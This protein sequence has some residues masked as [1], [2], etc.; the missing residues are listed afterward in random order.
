MAQSTTG[1][2]T[3]RRRRHCRHSSLPGSG[4]FRIQGRRENRVGHRRRHGPVGQNLPHQRL[5]HVY[6][7]SQTG[8]GRPTP[9]H[10]I[11][12]M[13]DVRQVT[14]KAGN[15]TATLRQ[16]PRFIDLERAPPAVNA[17]RCAPS[18]SPID[19]DHGPA[20]P[21]GGLQAL[22]P[23]HAGS[24]RHREKRDGTL[25]GRLPCQP[26]RPGVRSHSWPRANTRRPSNCSNRT[27]P[28]PASAAGSATTPAKPPAPAANWMNP[29]SIMALHRFLADW[30]REN[31]QLPRSP[32]KSKKK[33]KI[34]VV[35]SGPAGLTCAYFLAIDGICDV[36][37]FE[38]HDVLGGM[39]TLG[40]PSYR[41]PRDI[42]DELK[43]RS[44][45]FGRQRL[46]P[47]SILVKT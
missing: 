47:V 36:T 33:R 13:T 28:F 26:Q 42:I 39:L 22:P 21:Q 43:L 2:V 40:I 20:R 29:V 6:H 27:I 10:R 15:F 45:G 19:F 4:R 23:G 7:L 24:L 44:C 11:V 46:K 17:A 30:A 25:Q 14:G 38:K 1:A 35:G 16:R 31:G 32:K 12:T 34:A 8:G 9:Q 41:L 37:V 5:L 18:K 3:G